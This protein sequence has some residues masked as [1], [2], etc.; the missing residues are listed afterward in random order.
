M[1]RADGEKCRLVPLRYSERAKEVYE[2][3]ELIVMPG[4]GHGFRWAG[5]KEAKEKEQGVRPAHVGDRLPFEGM[6]RGKAL[7]KKGK[8]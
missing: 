2:N 8:R 5:R 4:Q 3:A 1:L 6:I 7:R